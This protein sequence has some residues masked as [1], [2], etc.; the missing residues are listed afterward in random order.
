MG[1]SVIAVHISSTYT[2]WTHFSCK[3]RSYSFSGESVSSS[4]ADE[5]VHFS[6][7]QFTRIG[8]IE[9]SPSSDQFTN[10]FALICVAYIPVVNMHRVSHRYAG[11]L[12]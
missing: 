1:S 10:R 6:V 9:S 3:E 8:R 5:Y 7:R 2:E 12:G 11:P 4:E